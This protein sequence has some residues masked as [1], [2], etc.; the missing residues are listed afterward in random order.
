VEALTV[1]RRGFHSLENRL[2]DGGKVVNLTHSLAALYPKED[3]WY[4]FPLG[5]KLRLEGLGQLEN[6]MTSSGMEPMTFQLVV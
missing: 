5:I 4:S 1:V 3:S 6:P 2:T